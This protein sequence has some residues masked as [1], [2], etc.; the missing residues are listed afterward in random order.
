MSGRAGNAVNFPVKITCLVAGWLPADS[1]DNMD[2]LRHG[3]TTPAHQH[4][5]RC[6]PDCP[7]WVFR[8]S[9]DQ[10]SARPRKETGSERTRG[11]SAPQDPAKGTRTPILDA[12]CPQEN[13]NLPERAST[14][15]QPWLESLVLPR[16][17]CQRAI[18]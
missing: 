16:A 9:A 3:A 5:D 18:N 2:L 10:I 17:I 7:D 11:T 15:S 1:I 14:L 8:L 12:R 6:L 4:R 13:G